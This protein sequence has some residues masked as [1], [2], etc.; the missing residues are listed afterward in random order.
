MKTVYPLQTK[1]AGG[2]TTNKVCGG[3]N[4]NPFQKSNDKGADQTA[5]MSSMRGP[6]KFCQRESNS[7]NVSFVVFL[8]VLWRDKGADQTAQMSRMV[9][10]FVGCMQQSLVFL[11]QGPSVNEQDPYDHAKSF[12]FLFIYNKH[13]SEYKYT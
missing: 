4:Y 3:Y 7:A 5:Q 8:F 9:Y 1:F 6:R 10:A 12:L 2:I 13:C 11:R